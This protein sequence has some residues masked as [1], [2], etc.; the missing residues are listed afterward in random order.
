MLHP[1]QR[2]P[3]RRV[4]IAERELKIFRFLLE[5]RFA[6]AEQLWRRFYKNGGD[7]KTAVYPWK[8]VEKRLRKLKWAGFIQTAQSHSYPH[9]FYLATYRAK[10]WLERQGIACPG[11]SILNGIDFKT[12]EHDMV[13]VDLRLI[14]EPKGFAWYSDRE[15]K[16]TLKS[17][18]IPDAVAV[19]GESRFA[20]EA[21]LSQKRR[22]RYIA[23]FQEYS[24]STWFRVLYFTASRS[25]ADYLLTIAGD[26][27]AAKIFFGIMPAKTGEPIVLKNYQ[28]KEFS[29]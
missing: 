3:W 6:T 17:G 16:S 13:L 27:L 18:P 9:Q 25:L 2:T 21:E 8:W 4:E 7:Y 19:Q 29:L 20:I 22:D 24:A 12:F 1:Q 26:L 11:L 10:S 14:L 5:M 15:L 23:L 28:E